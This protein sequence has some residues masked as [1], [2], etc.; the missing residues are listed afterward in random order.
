MRVG[1]W[2]CRVCGRMNYIRGS[3]VLK[4]HCGHDWQIHWRYKG[5]VPCEVLFIWK[6]N[7]EIV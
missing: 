2:K 6:E 4:N 5:D 3:N 1:R 7:S